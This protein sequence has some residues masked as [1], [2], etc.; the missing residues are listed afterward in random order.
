AGA[1]MT[2]QVLAIVQ[3]IFPPQEK[4]G[5]FALFGLTAGLASVAGPLVGGALISA[6]IWGLDW[7]PIFLV[8][9]PFGLL[10]ALAGAL[11]ITPTPANKALKNEFVGMGIFGL[12]IILMVFPLVEGRVFGWPWWSFAMMAASIVVAAAFYRW[13]HRRDRQ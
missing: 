8:N 6:D 10:A 4:G 11:I 13:Q 9:I 3:V 7:R 5:A 12:A 1:A 2:P